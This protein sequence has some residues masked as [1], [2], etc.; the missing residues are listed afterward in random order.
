MSKGTEERVG[1]PTLADHVTRI[2]NLNYQIYNW[3]F[4]SDLADQLRADLD[5]YRSSF[6]DAATAYDAEQAAVQARI[7]GLAQ[8]AG[9]VTLLKL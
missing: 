2:R 5:W 7:M 9:E 4:H 3:S 8:R 1:E 6:P